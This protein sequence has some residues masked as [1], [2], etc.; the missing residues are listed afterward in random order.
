MDRIDIDAMLDRAEYDH[1]FWY[2]FAVDIPANSQNTQ[3]LT[4]SSDADFLC[5]YITGRYTTLDVAGADAG[6]CGL[7]LQIIDM[8]FSVP[9]IDAL[10]NCALFLSPGR[11]R[12]STVAGDPSHQ[13]FFPI[14][15]DHVF[16]S[17]STIELRYA[18]NQATEN[19]LELLFMGRKLRR[20]FQQAP[21][22]QQ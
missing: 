18:N 12:T 3:Q 10:A 16:L 21:I 9:L 6:V 17:Q 14:E 20:K 5:Q 22:N 11:Q 4:I 1:P 13:L 7:S 15:L 8:G 19:R 2:P